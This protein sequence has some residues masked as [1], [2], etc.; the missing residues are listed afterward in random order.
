MIPTADLLTALR[1]QLTSDL[2]RMLP[3]L[4]VCFA[5]VLPLFL[6]VFTV[7]QR[8]HAS[9]IASPLLAIGLAHIVIHWNAPTAPAFAGLVQFDAF[10]AFFRGFLLLFALLLLLLG[11]ITG[12]PD[13]EDSA[14]FNTL[15]LGG[16]L[17]MMFMV[18][19]NHLLMIFIALEMA[20]LPSYALAGFWKG[21]RKSSEASLKYVL[22]GSAASG[23][24]LYG[25]SLLV[26]KFGT[27]SLAGVATGFSTMASSGTMDPL[28]VAGLALVLVGFAFKLSAVPVHMW[29]PDVF[30]GAAAEIGAFLSVASKAAAIGLTLRFVLKLNQAMGEA[31][32]DLL[33]QSLGMV[34]LSIAILTA[35]LG[36]LS[37]LAQTNL[38]RMLAYSTIA[39]AGYMLM[40][41]ATL[42]ASGASACLYYLAA[43][44]PTNLGAFA[45]IA[46]IRNRTGGETLDDVR[47]LMTRAPVL[48]ISLTIFLLSLLGLPP[49]AGFAG[50]FQVFASI[51]DASREHPELRNAYLALLIAGVLNTVIS[52]GYYLKVLRAMALEEPSSEE[53]KPASAAGSIYVALLAVAVVALGIWWNPITEII[54]TA[55]QSI[56]VK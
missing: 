18:S 52:A 50:K 45:V 56:F 8:I 26:V 44:L 19:A 30:E 39:H 37:A 12:L 47:G 40:A 36:N 10:A 38:K 3:E 23:L 55:V 54:A 32:A 43:Y 42:S 24:A 31:H 20:S 53:M 15:L 28:A 35:T 41:I 29:C 5:I 11:A 1:S 25:I 48:A 27:A 17:G 6:R 51:Y 7:F 4:C 33:P 46:L 22:F 34:L 16:I 14:D 13:R 2:M 21:K 49:L 9:L